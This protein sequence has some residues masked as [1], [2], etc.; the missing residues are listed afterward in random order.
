MTANAQGRPWAELGPPRRW[1]RLG[2]QGTAA[3][4]GWQEITALSY[5]RCFPA[6]HQPRREPI[7]NTSGIPGKNLDELFFPKVCALRIAL[8]PY[9][10]RSLRTP[11][12]A[13]SVCAVEVR[14]TK[15]M[16]ELART[17]WRKMSGRGYW[18][19]RQ[20]GRGTYSAVYQRIDDNRVRK[21]AHTIIRKRLADR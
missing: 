5:R 12:S 6:D 16:A 18:S 20:K 21:N 13:R 9:I 8:G 11:A 17:L 19:V 14:N 2:H 3:R 1:Q 7:V 10:A 4:A 15:S